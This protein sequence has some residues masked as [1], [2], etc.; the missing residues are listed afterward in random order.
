MN[1]TENCDQGQM[2]WSGVLAVCA[3]LYREIVVLRKSAPFIT[4]PAV[5][6]ISC[7]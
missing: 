2:G 5:V 6:T 1:A 4:S 3:D 7:Q